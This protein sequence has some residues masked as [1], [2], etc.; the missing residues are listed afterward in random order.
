MKN[1]ILIKIALWFLNRV[2]VEKLEYKNS[3][4]HYKK[5]IETFL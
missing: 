3:W 2:D 5:Q 4:K 1:K